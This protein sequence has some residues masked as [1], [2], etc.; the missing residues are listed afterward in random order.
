MA[1]RVL[2]KKAFRAFS[3]ILPVTTTTGNVS[4]PQ[5]RAYAKEGYVYE[6]VSERLLQSHG[7]AEGN[8]DLRIFVKV[9]ARR[10]SER[11]E[12]SVRE[13]VIIR[14]TMLSL[15]LIKGSSGDGFAPRGSEAGWNV[16]GVS[17]YREQ[18]DVSRRLCS[19]RL[20]HVDGEQVLVRFR[21][22]AFTLY[23]H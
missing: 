14:D 4:L 17:E 2:A 20:P 10:K 19:V 13:H 3:P 12:Y 21:K 16:R 22:K 6:D 5:R 9:S 8:V 15:L 11:L 7:D 18:S 1:A 23:K